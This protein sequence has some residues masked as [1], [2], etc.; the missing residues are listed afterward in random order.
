[1]N[2]GFG[3]PKPSSMPEWIAVSGSAPAINIVVHVVHTLPFAHY[4]VMFEVVLAAVNFLGL[5]GALRLGL[6]TPG[7]PLYKILLI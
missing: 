7:T 2:N 6:V 1:L 5:F 4:S 3:G